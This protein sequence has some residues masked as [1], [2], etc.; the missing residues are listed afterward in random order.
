MVRDAPT[1]YPPT[2][3][4]R[5]GLPEVVRAFKSFASRRINEYRRTRNAGI[6]QRDYYEH[7]IRGEASLGRIRRYITENPAR[8]AEGEENPN[9]CM[10]ST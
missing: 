10:G 4:Y 3:H 2:R 5:H 1:T 8:W 9:R 7:V 6:W